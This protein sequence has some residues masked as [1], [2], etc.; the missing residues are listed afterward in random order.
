MNVPAAVGVPEMVL[1]DKL[2]P[3][4]RLPLSMLHVMGV[5]PVAAR[6]WL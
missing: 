4:G 2:R 5:S 1:P 3:S 6:V